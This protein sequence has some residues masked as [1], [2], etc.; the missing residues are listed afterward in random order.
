MPDVRAGSIIAVDDVD[1]YDIQL[2]LS[3]DLCKVY[4]RLLGSPPLLAGAVQVIVAESGVLCV[5]C[6]F[7]GAPGAVYVVPTADGLCG[8]PPDEFSTDTL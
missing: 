5:T 2:E 3:F 1:R 8:D 4:V 6:M 7:V